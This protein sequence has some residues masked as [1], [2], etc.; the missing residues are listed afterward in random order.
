MIKCCK[1]LILFAVSI[2]LVAC[3]SSG[4]YKARLADI[5]NLKGEKQK[6]EEQLQ[7]K[8]TE[9]SNLKSEKAS[10]EET[11]NTK[12]SEIATLKD[13]IS[14]LEDSIKASNVENKLLE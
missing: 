4:E 7:A 13:K 8:E 12:S 1:T 10:L 5:D 14:N 9:L 2:L 3:V 6:L 11:I